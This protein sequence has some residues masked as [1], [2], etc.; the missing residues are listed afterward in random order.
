MEANKDE[1]QWKWTDTMRK[2]RL[3][4]RCVSAAAMTVAE[5]YSSHRRQA[6]RVEPGSGFTV[7]H[8]AQ[9]TVCID[10]SGAVGSDFWDRKFAEFM[11]WE[12]DRTKTESIVMA[13]PSKAFVTEGE[14]KGR[15][16]LELVTDEKRLV[17]VSVPAKGSVA[18]LSSSG[19]GAKAGKGQNLCSNEAWIRPEGNN[20]IYVHYWET[21]KQEPKLCS[22]ILDPEGNVFP[23]HRGVNG[24]SIF[25]TPGEIITQR[26]FGLG[27]GDWLIA[28]IR[29][30][31]AKKTPAGQNYD[32]SSE[33]ERAGRLAR[34]M[35]THPDSP[36]ASSDDNSV[37]SWDE[38]SPPPS[39]H[40]DEKGDDNGSRAALA[41]A[42]GITD[43]ISASDLSDEQIKRI[44]A[45]FEE[46]LQHKRVADR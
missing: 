46:A 27:N 12:I 26:S 4:A 1:R 28:E 34:R 32:H 29:R 10:D 11:N 30:R 13:D 35:A 6:D 41:C 42:K 15:P 40:G 45:G 17:K 16:T 25:P 44:V 2:D 33:V 7:T 21:S 37:D 36:N 23:L 24:Q 9:N 39:E 14:T 20:C 18:N 22:S 38:E 43:H 8:P 3:L 5:K 19:K 31:L